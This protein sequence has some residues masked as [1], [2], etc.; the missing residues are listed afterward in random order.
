MSTV[1]ATSLGVHSAWGLSLRTPE[2]GPTVT[3]TVTN[4]TRARA[5]GWA[6]QRCET[7]AARRRWAGRRP[8]MEV[9]LLVW[10]ETMDPGEKPARLLFLGLDML[11]CARAPVQPPKERR[12]NKRKPDRL[13]PLAQVKEL[14]HNALARV[15][16]ER[17]RGGVL[18]GRPR[19]RLR[20]RGVQSGVGRGGRGQV[21]GGGHEGLRRQGPQC[22][23]RQRLW[24]Q[25]GK[26]PGR[27]G[28]HQRE[29][30]PRGR[31]HRI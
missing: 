16:R 26:Q 11:P 31:L 10:L 30:L 8:S 19:Q 13:H 18:L 17:R 15:R 2:A 6:G 24:T 25:S 14:R 20:A 27:R 7:G 22:W 28:P 29:L 1:S 21:G 12:V 5:G 4:L 23:R 3:D 9:F